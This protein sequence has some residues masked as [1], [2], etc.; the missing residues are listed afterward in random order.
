MLSVSYPLS[1]CLC[2]NE[3]VS[4]RKPQQL[5]KCV[6]TSWGCEFNAVDFT[7]AG[8]EDGRGGGV[9]AEPV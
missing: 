9:V 5:M 7:E 1:L 4:H 3:S 2:I 6:S 8:R